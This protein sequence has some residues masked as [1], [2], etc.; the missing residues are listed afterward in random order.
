M[1]NSFEAI[2]ARLGATESRLGAIES[3]LGAI[4]S[5]LDDL[6]QPLQV[7]TNFQDDPKYNVPET[8]EYLDL[9]VPT[10]Y[11]KNSR[12]ELPSCKA[13]G[14]K[15]L[16]FYKSDLDAYIKQGRRKTNREIEADADQYLVKKK[17]PHNG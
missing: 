6:K 17:G 16:F 12:G 7:D 14:S 13:P 2:E 5:K 15:R 10:I 8:S 4:Y 9:S 11:S 3:R 1:N